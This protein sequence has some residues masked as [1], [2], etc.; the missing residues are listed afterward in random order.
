MT[1]VTRVRRVSELCEDT[2]GLAYTE[3]VA[4]LF[5]CALTFAIALTGLGRPL[6]EFFR[7]VRAVL[8]LPI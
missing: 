2:S 6:V 8:L 7:Q 3:Y 1:R 5:L 4:V